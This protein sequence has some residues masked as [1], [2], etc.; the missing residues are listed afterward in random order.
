MK[1]LISISFPVII[2][3]LG[4]VISNN[5]YVSGFI[6]DDY[7]ESDSSYA[8]YFPLAVGNSFTYAVTI[9][10][11]PYFLYK[12]KANITKDTIINGIKYF[13]SSGMPFIG[14]GWVRFD[15]ASSNLLKYSPGLGCSIYPDDI[16]L[17][18][19]RSKPFDQINCMYSSFSIRRCLDTSTFSVFSQYPSKT[20]NFLH[21]GLIYANTRYAKNFGIISDCSGEPPPCEQ[22]TT[23]GGCVINGVVYGDTS[24]T[25]IQSICNEIPKEYKLYQNYSN[26]FNPITNIKFDLPKN[27]FVTLKVLDI[28]GREIKTL[29]DEDLKSGTYNVSWDG[30]DYPSGVYFYKLVADD[31][32]MTK[33]MLLIK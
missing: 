12:F 6:G 3:F 27:G 25:G 22:F 2:L 31:Y 20:K 32:S 28:R 4:I 19:L 13:Y 1:K 15:T 21:D 8:V 33:K 29:V 14:N 24:M 17:D 26:P 7:Y 30:S 23:L 5:S 11:P 18:S 16:I 9:I 10:Y